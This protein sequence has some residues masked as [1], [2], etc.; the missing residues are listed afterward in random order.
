VSETPAAHPA[1]IEISLS[2]LGRAG[3]FG[4]L[5]HYADPAYYTLTYG[6]RRSDVDYYVRR[7][8]SVVGPVLEYGCGNGRISLP[9]VAAGATVFGVD[10][11]GPMLK[12]LE[13]RLA[14]APQGHR[15]RLRWLQGDMRTVELNERFDLI[16]APFNTFLHLYDQKDVTQFL[17]RVRDHLNIG[18]TFLFDV[19]IPRASELARK[20]TRRYRA[21]K[22]RDPTTGQWIQY[23]ERFEYDPVRQLRVIW[24]DFEPEDGSAPWTVPLT[25]RQFFPMELQSLLSCAGFDDLRIT[26]DFTDLAPDFEVDSLVFE[27]QR[28][29]PSRGPLDAAT[30]EP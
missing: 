13:T 2:T 5:A 27:C 30:T 9:M 14:R 26:A 24:M 25:H 16:L 20:P 17:A 21:P 3:D 8:R 18:G 11:S 29:R 12:D 28:G 15:Q 7:A 6:K 22:F 23:S 1:N 10:L 4:A 19:S